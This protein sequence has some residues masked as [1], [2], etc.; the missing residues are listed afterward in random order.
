MN[1][2]SV[3]TVLSSVVLAVA[4][5]DTSHQTS[6]IKKPLIAIIAPYRDLH[7]KQNRKQQLD[8]FIPAISEFMESVKRNSTYRIY[9]IEQSN[10]ERKFN[11]G[12]LLNIA[13][14]I[15]SA[16][17]CKALIFH[18]IDLLPSPG[19]FSSWYLWSYYSVL[20]IS[21]EIRE[22]KA[23]IEFEFEFEFE[24][25]IE[26]KLMILNSKRFSGS[27]DHSVYPNV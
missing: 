10:D 2:L 15:A 20:R 16:E 5:N 13:F 3:I 26:F 11:R 24:F 23:H 6:E 8:K 19:I 1:L 14:Q 9:V 21:N 12:K 17:G 4:T 18:D 22:K 25:D 27:H 7:K